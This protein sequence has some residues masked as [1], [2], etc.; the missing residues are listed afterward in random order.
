[1]KTFFQIPIGLMISILGTHAADL[2]RVTFTQVFNEVNIVDSKTTD[3]RDAKVSDAL[4][5]PDMVRTGP[6]S[7]AELTA[8][9][10]TITR[11]GA[12]TV[13]S[14]DRAGRQL[15]LDQ[16]SLLFHSPKGMGGGTV[17]TGKASAAVLGTTIVLVATPNGG[18]K[19]IVLE[20]EGKFTLGSGD[21]RRLTAGQAVY[22]LPESKGFSSILNINLSLLVKD[23]GLVKNYSAPLASLPKVQAAIVVQDDK[24]KRGV[25]QDTGLLAGNSATE[26]TVTVVDSVTFNA[27]VKENQQAVDKAWKRDLKID[28]ARIPADRVFDRSEHRYPKNSLWNEAVTRAALAQDITIDTENVLL[29][30]VAAGAGNGGWPP[31]FGIVAE[32]DLVIKDNV[33]F[34]P[35]SNRGGPPLASPNLLLAG[36]DVQISSGST[37]RYL[38]DAGLAVVAQKS[39]VCDQVSIQT[40]GGSVTLVSQGGSIQLAATDIQAHPDAKLD[41]VAKKGKVSA[42]GGSLTG[43]NISITASDKID[44]R[45]TDFHV[46][47]GVAELPSLAMQAETI[48][49]ANVNLPDGIVSLKSGAGGLAPG[50]N[51]RQAVRSGRVNFFENVRK[52]GNP[53]QN[54]V[55]GYDPAHFV[56]AEIFTPALHPVP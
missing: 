41:L 15:R 33:D 55:A 20:G 6:N 12:N 45:N 46:G 13:L 37:V 25:L 36:A 54:Y 32:Q 47:N 49:L 53:A 21:A 7:R 17:K 8:S 23:S 10:N 3:F 40:Q 43:G 30:R 38:A 35:A 5:A 19:G 29:P 26:T 39:L 24:R 28:S 22:V 11:I 52:H 18:F 14:F 50:A 27:A 1:M 9:D 56:A 42:V 4:F 2:S 48:V 51:T 44:I 31:L 34:H 16:G